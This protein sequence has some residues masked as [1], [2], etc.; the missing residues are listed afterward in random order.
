[1]AAALALAAPAAL[2][3]EPAPGVRL[4]KV[5]DF[6]APVHVT[7]PPGDRRRLVVTEQDGRLIMVRDGR[8][9]AQPFLDISGL[10]SSGGERGLLSAAFA[11]DY[12]QSGRF[13]VYYTDR[14]GPGDIRIE[15][16]RR[17]RV[18]PDRADPGSRRVILVQD[19][20]T[21]P[22]HNGGQL[23][24][25]PDGMLYAGL[26]DGG[27]RDDPFNNAQNLGSLLGKVLRIA[28]GR[29]SGGRPY[30]VPS[31]NPFVGR[32]GARPEVYAY[33]LRN[34]YRFSFDRE[35]GD[36]TI[37]D[38]GQD[39][40]EEVDFAPLG[41]GAGANY[42]WSRY[43]GARLNRPER[44]APGA[45]PPVLEYAHTGRCSSVTG[46]YVVRDRSLTGLFGR[47]LYGDYCTGELRSAELAL[48]SARD[49]RALGLVVPTVSSFGED[50]AG[51]IYAASL[52]GPVY[53]FESA[54]GAPPC[55]PDRRAPRL[56]VG[57][58]P[59]QRP[60]AQRGILASAGC[61][62]PC[63]VAA[64]A[65]VSGRGMRPVTSATVVRSVP[66]RASQRLRLVFSRAAS[67]AIARSLRRQRLT[68][69]VTVTARDQ[70]G[71]AATARRTVTLRR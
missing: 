59:T 31:D 55:P 15:E 69:I 50:A 9:L 16:F 43:E 19:H 12:A 17:S 65:R 62:E 42:G 49:D 47:Y 64:S 35:N 38:V 68:A 45:V 66:P 3:G 8:R 70:S 60:L 57:G 46:G 13:Y 1:M 52:E 28:P 54:S 10:V 27:A 61:D 23:Q 14:A 30:G 71:N 25:G 26:G 4:V 39:A 7:A 32:A 20:S 18:N 2:A 6:G 51:C 37:G 11:P 5:G 33:G 24:F 21:F 40:V 41:R 67:A 29:P 53:R 56:G 58:S 48:P 44:E 34:P 36:L 22:N 63:R